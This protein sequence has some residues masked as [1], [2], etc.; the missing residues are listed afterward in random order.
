KL[1]AALAGKTLG[2]DSAKI[3]IRAVRGTG[4]NYPELIAALTTAGKLTNGTKQLSPPELAALLE[5]IKASGDPVKGE[6]VFR[7]ADLNCLK[8]HAIGGAGGAVGP[9]LVSIGGSAQLDYLV[10]SLLDPSKKIK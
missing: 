3:S 8:C 5:E 4:G 1:T 10:E 2:S 7:R 9:D 6:T